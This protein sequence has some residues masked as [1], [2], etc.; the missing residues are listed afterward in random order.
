MTLSAEEFIHRLAACVA[1]RIPTHPLLRF[2]GEPPSE[3]ETGTVPA[4]A[5]H[6]RSSRANQRLA[7]LRRRTGGGSKPDASPGTPAP[8]G[9][10]GNGR[11]RRGDQ[12]RGS[13]HLQ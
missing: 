6:A 11:T 7:Q 4:L 9:S 3:G 5:R 12:E 10:E 1:G 2:A 13:A 8:A